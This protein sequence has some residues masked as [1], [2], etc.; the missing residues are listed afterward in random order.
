MLCLFINVCFGKPLVHQFIIAN[1]KW[2]KAFK[3]VWIVLNLFALEFHL[4]DNRGSKN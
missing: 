3:R 1:Q 4:E 2:R